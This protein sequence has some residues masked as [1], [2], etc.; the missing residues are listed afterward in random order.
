MLWPIVFPFKV[1]SAVMAILVATFTILAPRIGWKRIK[2]FVVSVI[3][4][5]LAFIPAFILASTIIDKFRFGDFEYKS[6]SEIPTSRFRRYMPE[7]ATGIEMRKNINGYYAKYTLTESHLDAFLDKLWQ[8]YGNDSA[9]QRG[10]M[11]GEGK[12]VSPGH[13]EYEFDG[14]DWKC[15][16]NTI[17]L[18]GPTEGDGGGATYYVDR[19]SQ[20]VF[21]RTG[22]W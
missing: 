18:Y 11:S 5:T 16:K 21:Q 2:A 20:R 9:V 10:G 19:E 14:L 12:L 1:T 7:S 4:A 8:S 6:Y 3:V 22:F 15:P 13:F 17:L